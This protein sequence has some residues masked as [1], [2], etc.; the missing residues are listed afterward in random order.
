MLKTIQHLTQLKPG[1]YPLDNE[2]MIKVARVASM[3]N[4]ADE[5][6]LYLINMKLNTVTKVKK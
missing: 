2:A 5:D 6:H 4:K 3:M 1:C